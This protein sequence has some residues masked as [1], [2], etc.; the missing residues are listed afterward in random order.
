MDLFNFEYLSRKWDVPWGGRVLVSGSFLW[1]SAFI[2]IGLFIAPQIA[3]QFH[4]QYQDP[5]AANDKAYFLLID[6]LC[7]TAFGIGLIWALTRPYSPLP[8][9]LFKVSLK[10]PFDLRDGWLLWALIGI[11]GG[12]VG[13]GLTAYAVSLLNPPGSESTGTAE[14]VASIL[15]SDPKAFISIF[16]VT[17]L[18]APVL[19][20]IIFRGFVLTTLTKWLP[21]P[22]AV[23]VSAGFF[24]AA[25]L[26][27]HDFAQLTALGVI[28]GLTY[29]R[30][31]NL[32]TATTSQR[33][34]NSL[35]GCCMCIF[36]I[37]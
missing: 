9:N 2:G 17:S 11:L 29:S 8:S 26:S 13:V 28:L 30:T 25:H 5:T 19:E 24:G 14:A 3:D 32:L 12:L 6:Q 18:L 4:L 1:I 20:E 36:V 27:S 7:E 31:Q 16:T 15:T 22:T 34:C 10:D 35:S 23:F 33:Y 37:V 21:T